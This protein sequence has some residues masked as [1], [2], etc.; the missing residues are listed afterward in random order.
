MTMRIV[1]FGR[2]GTGKTR[3]VNHIA[4]TIQAEGNWLGLV[5]ASKWKDAPLNDESL[6]W[7][8]NGNSETPN[9]L[10][11]T[12]LYEEQWPE[13]E[14]KSFIGVTGANE[15]RVAEHWKS[16]LSDYE[17]SLPAVLVRCQLRWDHHKYKYPFFATIEKNKHGAPFIEVFYRLT[18]DGIEFSKT[19]N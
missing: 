16:S 5:D 18:A 17:E 7:D 6:E 11:A 2:S 19:R 14:Y 8:D 12:D 1:V 15:C 13:A 4:K 10:T 3:V 9:I